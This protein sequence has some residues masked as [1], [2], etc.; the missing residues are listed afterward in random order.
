ME[1]LAQ[2]TGKRD[3]DLTPRGRLPDFACSAAFD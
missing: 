2:A 1:L 3:F